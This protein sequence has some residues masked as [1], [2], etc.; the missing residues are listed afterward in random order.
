MPGSNC[1]IVNCATSRYHKEIS[2]FKLLTPKDKFGKKWRR[3]MLDIITRDRETDANLNRQTEKD[4]VHICEN[5]V[6]R[7]GKI[8][9]KHGPHVAEI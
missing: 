1:V 5:I 3:D 7:N 2:S 4:T 6:I 8:I 9:W